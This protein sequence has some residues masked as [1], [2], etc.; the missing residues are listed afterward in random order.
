MTDHDPTPEPYA[1]MTKR[2]LLSVMEQTTDLDE[3][4]RL[5][6]IMVGKMTPRERQAHARA[7]EIGRF[8]VRLYGA[9]GSAQCNY[10]FQCAGALATEIAEGMPP[11]GPPEAVN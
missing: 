10:L 2:Q 3:W 8:L 4:E 1:S 9:R 5:N 6:E 7:A 11:V